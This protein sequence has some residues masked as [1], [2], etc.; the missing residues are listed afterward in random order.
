MTTIRTF[1]AAE[2]A[3][4]TATEADALRREMRD[5]LAWEF[6]DLAREGRSLT[7]E[8]GRASA[9]SDPRRTAALESRLATA[10]RQHEERCAEYDRKAA[11]KHLFAIRGGSYDDAIRHGVS[12]HGIVPDADR[13]LVIAARRADL[14]L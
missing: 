4:L 7:H 10:G 1:T 14:G 13:D 5:E 12:S 3:A 11:L 8:A 9:Y 6:D 2:I